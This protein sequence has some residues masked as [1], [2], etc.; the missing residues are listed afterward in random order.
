MAIKK[1]FGAVILLLVV[2]CAAD[3]P[4][5]KEIHKAHQI[6]QRH[7]PLQHEECPCN[8]DELC[9]K[10]K[11]DVVLCHCWTH[12]GDYCPAG[13]DRIDETTELCGHMETRNFCTSNIV[14][15]KALNHP[16]AE[17]TFLDKEMVKGSSKSLSDSEDDEKDPAKVIHADT[18]ED[19]DDDGYLKL[20]IV[21]FILWQIGSVG[22]GMMI[23]GCASDCVRMLENTE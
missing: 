18:G 5:H 12:C 21:G 10:S 14:C 9:S 1:Y 7:W 3:S 11:E 20:S 6:H 19:D 17:G 2:G 23:C 16:A 15:N 13:F 4:T 22:L 8:A